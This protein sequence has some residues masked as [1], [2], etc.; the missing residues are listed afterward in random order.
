VPGKEE[1]IMSR[2]VF[3]A[4]LTLFLIT[5]SVAAQGVRPPDISGTWSPVRAATAGGKRNVDFPA[6][7]KIP[8]QQATKARYESSK[9]MSDLEAG[10]VPRGAVRYTTTA[11]LPLDIVQTPQKTLF[12]FNQHSAFRRIYTDGRKHPE[13]QTP[14]YF[15]HSI[16]R[17]EGSTLVVDTVGEK[18]STWLSVTDKG[19]PHSDALHVTERIRLIE[20]GKYL[21]SEITVED[22]KAYTAPMKVVR[23][24]ERTANVVDPEFVCEDALP[25]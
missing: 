12:L 22:P 15:G 3:I 5:G 9:P 13:N 8:F 10:C 21:E 17:W 4:T 24:W 20:D 7:D 6:P 14:S 23:Y 25:Q 16:G 1:Q 18:E 2:R 11:M 19:L